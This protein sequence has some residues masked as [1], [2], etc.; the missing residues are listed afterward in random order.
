METLHL[1]KATF[2]IT[3]TQNPEPTDCEPID[4]SVE[5]D[6]V[7]NNEAAADAW[8]QANI[9]RLRDCY[10]DDCSEVSVDSD[11]S[12]GNLDEDCGLTGEIT[13]V[14]TISDDCG[15]SLTVTGTFTIVDTQGPNITNPADEDKR[16]ECDGSG[17]IQELEA[18]LEANGNA[19]AGDVCGAVTW[20][21]DFD[22][23]S[24]LCGETGTVEVVFTAKD[25]C[26]N[27]ST[28]T[29]NFTIEDKTPPTPIC[30]DIV[31]QID[32][33]C[34]IAITPEDIDNGS[35]DNC[36]E[37]ASRSLSKTDFGCLPDIGDN[38]VTLTVVDDCGNEASCTANVRVEKFDLALQTCWQM[39]K[40]KGSIQEKK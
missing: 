39:V 27:E 40:M 8:D 32:G 7:T 38:E 23:L 6:G 17:N 2:T 24:N 16:V 29:G 15:N 3:D 9:I 28:T 25:D 33:T 18:W 21:N 5:C 35:F 4:D 11:Y 20:T 14:Y 13:V 1:K 37:I 22:E 34:A 30:Q 26:G 10:D 31:V 36:G 12:F 19:E